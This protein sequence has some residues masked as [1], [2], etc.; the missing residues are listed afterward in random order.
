MVKG[1]KIVSLEAAH[2]SNIEQPK[3]YT[4]AV[5]NFLKN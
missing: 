3:P 2:L 4:D 5:L 1:S